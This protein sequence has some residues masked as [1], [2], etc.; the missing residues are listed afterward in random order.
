M[1]YHESSKPRMHSASWIEVPRQYS[2][3]DKKVPTHTK[4]VRLVRRAGTKTLATPVKVRSIS[5]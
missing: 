4:G 1:S 2:W 5:K 3:V